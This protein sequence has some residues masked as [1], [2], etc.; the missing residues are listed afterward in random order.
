PRRRALCAR[1]PDPGE[2]TAPPIRRCTGLLHG[3]PG[4]WWRARSVRARERREVGRSRA[5]RT[6][7]RWR[8]RVERLDRMMRRLA[9]WLLLLILAWLVVEPLALVS[10]D[11]IRKDGVWTLDAV[12][13]FIT[14][15]NEWRAAF[16]SLWLAIASVILG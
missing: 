15:R 12:R 10:I 14:E 2:G 7:R 8:P 4:R 9:P 5:S 13:T 16:N 1:G 3:G 11:A 6:D